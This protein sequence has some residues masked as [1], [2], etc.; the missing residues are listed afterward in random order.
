MKILLASIFALTLL[1]STAASA[2][3]LGVDVHV[4]GIGAGAHIGGGHHHYRHCHGWGHRHHH[5]YCRSWY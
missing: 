4:G 2:D 1:G 3:I 5:R